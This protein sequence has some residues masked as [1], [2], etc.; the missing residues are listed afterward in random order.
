MINKAGKKLKLNSNLFQ[1]LKFLV[2][3]S[4]E[5]Y[6][7]I[8]ITEDKEF[9]TEDDFWNMKLIKDYSKKKSFTQGKGN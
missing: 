1:Q 6:F 5:E 7:G 4:G 2:L 8:M 9:M 3:P